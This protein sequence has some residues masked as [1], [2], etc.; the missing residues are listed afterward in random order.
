MTQSYAMGAL[1]P[2]KIQ[3]LIEQMNRRPLVASVMLPT[4]PVYQPSGRPVGNSATMQ[5][6]CPPIEDQ[7]QYGTCHDDQWLAIP[8]N[9][10]AVQA[11]LAVLR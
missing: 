11:W 1:P 2:E 6:F 8:E 10:A 4:D 5:Q 3:A 7:L 9:A